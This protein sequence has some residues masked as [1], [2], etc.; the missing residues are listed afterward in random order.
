M[1]SP[2]LATVWLC[3]TYICDFDV[4]IYSW[5]LSHNMPQLFYQHWLSKVPSGTLSPAKEAQGAATWEMVVRPLMGHWRGP[6]WCTSYISHFNGQVMPYYWGTY[7]SW[8][9]R[10][11]DG[12]Q[13]EKHLT[14]AATCFYISSCDFLFNVQPKVAQGCSRWKTTSEEIDPWMECSFIFCYIYDFNH[15]NLAEKTKNN[16]DF[17][18]CNSLRFITFHLRLFY[19]VFVMGQPRCSDFIS[20]ENDQR[21]D[22]YIHN[23]ASMQL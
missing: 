14:G 18:L 4:Y 3:H 2:L 15:S 20:L 6:S 1:F 17:D 10:R 11:G 22:A 13:I 7:N 19:P 16:L 5:F 12:K 9:Q 23:C 8:D 21:Q